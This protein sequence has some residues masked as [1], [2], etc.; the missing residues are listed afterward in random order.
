LALSEPTGLTLGPDGSS[1]A[2]ATRGATLHRYHGDSWTDVA[3]SFSHFGA[4][5]DASGD[6]RLRPADGIAL[7]RDRLV[8]TDGANHKLR[9][10]DLRTGYV[11][12]IASS[13]VSAHD[14]QMPRGV[15]VTSDGYTSRTLE[16]PH[17]ARCARP[18]TAHSG[19]SAPKAGLRSCVAAIPHRSAIALSSVRNGTM[20]VLTMG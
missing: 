6:A 13:G 12:T 4:A 15:L 7:G 10:L 16:S 1:Y 20:P 11:T 2:I 18:L 9:Q 19:R 17:R 14:L 5:D 8:F 3:G